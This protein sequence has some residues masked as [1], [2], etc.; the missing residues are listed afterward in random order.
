M[1]I[2]SWFLCHRIRLTD[3]GGPINVNILMVLVSS[4]QT[5]RCWRAHQCVSGVRSAEGGDDPEECDY[6]RRRQEGEGGVHHHQ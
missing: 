3:V 5:D 1:L 2:F 4:Y 6:L